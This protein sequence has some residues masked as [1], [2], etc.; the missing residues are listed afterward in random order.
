MT[1][2]PMRHVS[3]LFAI[4]LGDAIASVGQGVAEAQRALDESAIRT[5]LDIYEAQGDE[6]LALLNSIG[7]RPSF[8]GIRNIKSV[9]K[10][11]MH[12]SAEETVTSTGIATPR[13]AMRAMPV[14]ATTANK[15]N[16]SGDASTELSFEIVPIPPDT[17]VIRVPNVTGIPAAKA[18]AILEA[19]GLVIQWLDTADTALAD[20]TDISL[21]T[22]ATQVPASGKAI[23]RGMV[24]RVGVE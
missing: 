24:V 16:M 14:N 5:T 22:V 19:E 10:I 18:A 3:D 21:L 23:A 1:T 13:V 11:A 17:E 2:D 4:R 20:G 9:M 7:Y 15:Y 6:G 8:Y 12:F